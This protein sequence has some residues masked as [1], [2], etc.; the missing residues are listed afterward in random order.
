MTNQFLPIA[1]AYTNTG[2]YDSNDGL[3]FI[4]GM[5]ANDALVVV[6]ANT[7][8]QRI[9]IYPDFIF[10]GNSTV[11]ATLNSTAYTGTANSGGGSPGGSNT[12]LQFNDSGAFG[13]NASLTYNKTTNT[14][15]IGNST[16][17]TTI[18]STATW[19][20]S[21]V[22]LANTT[23]FFVGSAGVSGSL[24]SVGSNVTMNLTT[25]FVG[26][27]TANTIQNSSGF[28]L[29]G[30]VVGTTSNTSLATN[31]VVNGG[32]D[33]SQEKG[34]T[35]TSTNGGYVVDQWSLVFNG[36][37]AVSALQIPSV[38]SFPG[39]SS[40]L[41]VTVQTAQA[42]LS[43]GDYTAI[44]QP[45]EGLRVSRLN[46]GTASAK[47]ITL[48]FW[49]AHH[50][51]GT[52]SGSI[53]NSGSTRSYPFTYTQNVADAT[54]FKTIT[55]T[56][57][58]TGTWLTTNVSALI[59]FFAVGLGTTFTGTANTWATGN[60]LGATGT[61][62]GVAATSDVFRITGVTLLPGSGVLSSANITDYLRPYNE[63][64]PL[65]QRYWQKLTWTIEGNASGS[66]ARIAFTT[67]IPTMRTTPSRTRITTGT[68]SNIRAS[69]PTSYVIASPIS[70]SSLYC[71]AESAAAGQVSA[72][73]FVDGFS[74]R[75]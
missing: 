4:T 55:I 56:G 67:A 24:I 9:V 68:S 7:L 20:G 18:N 62:N 14:I 40:Y 42:S 19:W 16:V 15:S 39:Y 26:N 48:G 60:Y 73:N 66:L 36:T 74:A 47:T 63:E 50:R 5:D 37:M 8:G 22:S 59:V 2:V 35:A 45:I 28:Y 53:R 32:F 41:S 38:T 17:N 25:M 12:H 57:D 3:N 29:N 70:D 51:T 43:A 6:S 52:Y 44:Y 69:D 64:L 33:V 71:S 61:T 72:A 31:I 75:M 30:V 21:G 27:S 10:V 49:T 13:G 58:T 1:Y 46:F 34:T 11:F 65:C 54:E 23:G